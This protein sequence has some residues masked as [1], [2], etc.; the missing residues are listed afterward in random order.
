VAGAG[1]Q[2][3]VDLPF[4]EVSVGVDNSS[5]VVRLSSLPI[6]LYI[7]S[8]PQVHFPL[9]MAVSSTGGNRPLPDVYTA[10]TDSLWGEISHIAHTLGVGKDRQASQG[11]RCFL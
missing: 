7:A 5:E 1:F 2:A 4:I 9:S 8:I 11:S 10:V 6:A 3:L